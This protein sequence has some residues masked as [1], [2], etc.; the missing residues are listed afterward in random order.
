MASACSPGLQFHDSW[1][2]AAAAGFLGANRPIAAIRRAGLGAKK[3]SFA[4]ESLGRRPTVQAN[5][6]TRSR[7]ASV[8]I[9][10]ELMANGADSD[11][12]AAHF[13]CGNEPGASKG[14]DEFTLPVVQGASGLA[15]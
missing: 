15:A 2:R 14:N 5:Y 12:V 13:K 10:L 11:N 4:T 7:S 3:L 1:G 6:Q 9:L 8:E